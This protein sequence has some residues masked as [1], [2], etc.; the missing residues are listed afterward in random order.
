MN[1]LNLIVI[2]EQLD[3]MFDIPSAECGAIITGILGA[4][5]AIGGA[6]SS[7]FGGGGGGEQV[8]Q[9]AQPTAPDTSTAVDQKAAQEEQR[10]RQIN[11]QR[12]NTNQTG[13]LGAWI[14]LRVPNSC[15]MFAL[16]RTRLITN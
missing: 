4:F 10:R 7:L 1:E 9:M 11:A 8:Q 13:G 14:C 5:S 2:L 6:V 3:M 15:V 12:G 16:E